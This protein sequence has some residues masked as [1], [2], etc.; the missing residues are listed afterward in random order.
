MVVVAP[1]PVHMWPW[2][3]RYKSWSLMVLLRVTL[4]LSDLGPISVLGT[5][6]FM[7]TSCLSQHLEYQGILLSLPAP[8]PAVTVSSALTRSCVA[9][10]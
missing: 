3:P 8:V 6:T 9:L 7:G 2:L 1:G 5:V 4:T 10:G